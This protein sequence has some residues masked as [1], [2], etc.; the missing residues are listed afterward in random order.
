MLQKL[1]EPGD[2][3]SPATSPTSER[4]A[5]VER[6]LPGVRLYEPELPLCACGAQVVLKFNEISTYS[7]TYMTYIYGS[8]YLG[9]NISYTVLYYII[10]YIHDTW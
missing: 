7:D 8:I 2:D 6:T 10:I 5:T 1:K 9:T 3:V 4:L